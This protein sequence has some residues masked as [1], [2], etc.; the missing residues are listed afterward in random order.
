MGRGSA[1]SV[2]E[3]LRR[4]ESSAEC[5][6]CKCSV[7]ADDVCMR[8]VCPWELKVNKQGYVVLSRPLRQRIK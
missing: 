4:R 2:A 1:V 7:R 3:P 6:V 5:P 8:S